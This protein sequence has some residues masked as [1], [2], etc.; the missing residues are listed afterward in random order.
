MIKSCIPNIYDVWKKQNWEEPVLFETFEPE[1]INLVLPINNLGEEV[2]IKS[3]DK[4]VTIKSDDKKVTINSQ[5]N[6]EQKNMI[7]QFVREHGSVKNSELCELLGVKST[8]IKQLLYELLD[9]GILAA[10]GSNKNRTYSL[11][12]E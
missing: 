9:E 2:T 8:R 10:N 1:R 6:L 11:K 5:K 7:V 4:K 3:D 12:L